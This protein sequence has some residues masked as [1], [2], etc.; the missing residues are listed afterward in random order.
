MV[1][2]YIIQYSLLMPA[3]KIQ[4]ELTLVHKNRA[5]VTLP[6]DVF[7]HTFVHGEPLCFQV[8]DASLLVGV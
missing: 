3:P 1:L 2:A 4:W 8:T 7:V 5:I 6:T